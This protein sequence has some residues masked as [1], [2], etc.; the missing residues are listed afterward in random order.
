M[1]C[2]LHFCI[3]IIVI[4]HY[5]L[6]YVF[7]FCCCSPLCLW[8][9][10]ILLLIVL[11]TFNVWIVPHLYLKHI[12]F[13]IPVRLLHNIHFI[14]NTEYII[15]YQFEFLTITFLQ[16]F[17]NFVSWLVWERNFL[18]LFLFLLLFKGELVV[19]GP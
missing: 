3:F 17:E 19:R 7:F 12:Y 2:I 4:I 14:R 16:V 11:I 13:E 6:F 1:F 15:L 5:I 8:D 9:E 10:S 18:S